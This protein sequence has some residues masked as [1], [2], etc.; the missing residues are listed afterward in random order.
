M[1]LWI[2][3][4]LL[5]INC[6]C[7]NLDHSCTAMGRVYYY[8]MHYPWRSTCERFIQTTTNEKMKAKKWDQP[9]VMNKSSTARKW[10]KKKNASQKMTDMNKK[11]ESKRFNIYAG[12]R[13]RGAYLHMHVHILSDL[14]PFFF[15]IQF[16]FYLVLLFFFFFFFFAALSL[17]NTFILHVCQNK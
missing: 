6:I 1:L 15:P 14:S 12:N 10:K 8:Y 17:D 5:C 11:K 4:I 13:K 9:N 16:L 3:I 2:C 7:L